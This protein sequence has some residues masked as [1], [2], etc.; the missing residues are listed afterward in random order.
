MDFGGLILGA[1]SGIGGISISGIG[2]IPQPD[3][4]QAQGFV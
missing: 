1:S 4:G 3:S 2:R